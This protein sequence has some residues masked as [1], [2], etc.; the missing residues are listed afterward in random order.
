MNRHFP[1]GKEYTHIQVR[2]VELFS[3]R[4]FTESQASLKAIARISIENISLITRRPGK[5]QR[6]MQQKKT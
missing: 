2:L 3:G 5:P 4:H 1:G 6:L